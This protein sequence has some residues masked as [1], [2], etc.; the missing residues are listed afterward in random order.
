M[1]S[2]KRCH[3]TIFVPDSENRKKALFGLCFSNL[4]FRSPIG[5]L[6]RRFAAAAGLLFFNLNIAFLSMEANVSI[7]TI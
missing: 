6:F 5:A 2:V 7:A 3:E 4:S 1:K